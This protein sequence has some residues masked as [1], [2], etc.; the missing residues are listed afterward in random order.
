MIRVTVNFVSKENMEVHEA[1]ELIAYLYFDGKIDQGSK[2]ELELCKD[3]IA[4]I[5]NNSDISHRTLALC[6]IYFQAVA[7][8]PFGQ[9]FEV[10]L[11]I[12]MFLILSRNFSH[13]LLTRVYGFSTNLIS[14]TQLWFCF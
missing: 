4:Q 8:K 3:V 7:T 9:S 12:R 10:N 5:K 6:W 11:Q 2:F 14:K 1:V 13:F